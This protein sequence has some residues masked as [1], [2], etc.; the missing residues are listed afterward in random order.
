MVRQECDGLVSLKQ[1]EQVRE[2]VFFILRGK[3]PHKS[4]F[5]DNKADNGNL[6]WRKV[7]GNS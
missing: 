7:K 3:K 2:S 4:R 1:V 6:D 5:R